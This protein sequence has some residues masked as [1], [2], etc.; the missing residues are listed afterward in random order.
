MR[1]PKIT[2]LRGIKTGPGGDSVLIQ[3]SDGD[4]KPHE[5][6]ITVA[7]LN[8]MVPLLI[9]ALPAEAST[10]GTSRDVQPVRL[11]SCAPAVLGNGRPM[12][13]MNLD[14]LRVAV[15]LHPKAV[16]HLQDTL[17]Q[18]SALLAEDHPPQLLS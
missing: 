7:A 6:P 17:R 5:M 12:L 16:A 11:L 15:E 14:G 18:L 2:N 9:N 10:A 8:A 13:N 4:G 1:L 3:M